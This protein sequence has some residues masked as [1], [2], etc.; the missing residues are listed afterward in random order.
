MLKELIK[1]DETY[2]NFIFEKNEKI[3]KISHH[4][5]YRYSGISTVN[6]D[7]KEKHLTETVEVTN[8]M[9]LN[10]YIKLIIESYFN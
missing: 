10:N 9:W 8:E 7:G 3:L 5:F 4:S 6:K 2:N 1:N